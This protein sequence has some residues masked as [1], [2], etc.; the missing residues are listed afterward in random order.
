MT[1]EEQGKIVRLILTAVLIAEYGLISL[2]GNGDDKLLLRIKNALAYCRNVQGF[3]I[4]NPNASAETKA[5]FKQSF[6]GNEVVLLTE[7]LE[8]CFP[9]KEES[10]QDIVDSIKRYIEENKPESQEVNS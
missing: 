7:L 6:L 9:M 4:N 1:I 3:F 8:L 5:I 10:I 2:N